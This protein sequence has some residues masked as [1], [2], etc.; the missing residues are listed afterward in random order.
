MDPLEEHIQFL[1]AW[2]PVTI[3]GG[4][5]PHWQ[6]A[7]VCVFVTFRLSDSIPRNL[8]TAWEAERKAWL[9]R[10]P[11]SRDP[12]LIEAFQRSYTTRIEEW[13]DRG[14]GSCLLRSPNVAKILK[15]VLHEGDGQICVLHGW[16]IMPNHVHILFSPTTRA[17]K[18]VLK[19]WKGT[20]ARRI[21]LALDRVSSTVWMK[22]Y[23]DRLIRDGEHFRRCVNYI[24]NNPKKAGLADQGYIVFESDLVKR[25][26]PIE[27]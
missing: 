6:Q 11:E 1:C 17:I 25:L 15:G 26:V 7:R 18:D 21:N 12:D 20:S 27:Q 9:A 10:H 13:L 19:A 24:R 22:G 14:Q 3:H 5:L 8:L 23:H 2:D 16:V 4:K